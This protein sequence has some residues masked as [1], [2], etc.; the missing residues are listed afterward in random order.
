VEPQEP[1]RIVNINDAYMINLAFQGKT[2]PFG[3]P[4]DPCY[5]NMF[6]PCL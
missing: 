3:C 2:Y 1:N 5:D 4:F 6:E